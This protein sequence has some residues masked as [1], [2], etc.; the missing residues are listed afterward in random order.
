MGSGDLAVK[1][2]LQYK[3]GIMRTR[4]EVTLG[5]SCILE[6]KVKFL[7]SFFFDEQAE[8]LNQKN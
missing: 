8:E 6:V 4:K 2:F 5:S 3:E 1:T 7:S